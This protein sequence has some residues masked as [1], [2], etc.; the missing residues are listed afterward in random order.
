[1]SPNTKRR[2]CPRIGP[3]LPCPPGC[4]EQLGAHWINFIACL[5]DTLSLRFPDAAPV[6]VVPRPAR[7]SLGLDPRR[8][9]RIAMSSAG[10]N[11]PTE[12][13]VICAH[14]HI[15][16]E[17]HIGRWH[18]FNPGSV[19]IPLDGE[20]SASYMII[21]GDHARLEPRPPIAVS[22]LNKTAHLRR[23]RQTAI[24][25]SAAASPPCC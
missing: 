15:P 21:D 4:N 2:A 20:R 14:S 10:W 11:T 9:R 12:E 6:R 25:R 16:M 18:V 19:G 1:M 23:L 5:P 17:R 13:T 22:H 8:Y 3:A 7:Q 24:C